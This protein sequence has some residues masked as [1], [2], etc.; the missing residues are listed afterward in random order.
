MERKDD[1]V[2][3][4]GSSIRR[5]SIFL[6]FGRHVGASNATG[7]VSFATPP[8]PLVLPPPPPPPT[9]SVVIAD[10]VQRINDSSAAA[11]IELLR[12]IS[13]LGAATAIRKNNSRHPKA[14]NLPI[15]SLRT[16][17]PRASPSPPTQAAAAPGAYFFRPISPN[18]PSILNYGAAQRFL[19]KRLPL[20]YVDEF[21]KPSEE[22]P[23]NSQIRLPLNLHRDNA[24]VW[25]NFEVTNDNTLTFPLKTRGLSLSSLC[26]TTT[27]NSIQDSALSKLFCLKPHRADSNKWILQPATHND[28]QDKFDLKSRKQYFKEQQ[29]QQQ[30]QSGFTI[31]SLALLEEEQQQE[32][33]RKRS[34]PL[35]ALDP[36]SKPI[37][38]KRHLNFDS[39]A[40]N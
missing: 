7:S 19:C 9:T 24:N 22:L 16:S 1:N 5:S 40:D 33:S 28:C 34:S 18:P 39:T 4:Y 6:A 10:D 2:R 17:T 30:Q 8:P 14:N 32:N 13:P 15:T 11:I 35:T 29:Q 27:A 12:N 38:K 36:I 23:T 31:S 3:Q 21:F 26:T 25:Y 20:A 37:T